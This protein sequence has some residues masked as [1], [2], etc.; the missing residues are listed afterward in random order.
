MPLQS[1]L[2]YLEHGPGVVLWLQPLQVRDRVGRLRGRSQ[3]QPEV[4]SAAEEV[5]T[6]LLIEI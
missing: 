1:T 2:D 5:I 6:G 4:R 3:L